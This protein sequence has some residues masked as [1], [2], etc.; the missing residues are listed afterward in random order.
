MS[1]R[2][3]RRFAYPA[4]FTVLI[5]A[6]C[7]TQRAPDQSI[8]GRGASIGPNFSVLEHH[9]GPSRAGVYA[10]PSF[11]RSAAAGI[12]LDFTTPV[13]GVTNAQPLFW[14]GQETEPDLVLMVTEQNQVLAIDASTGGVFWRRPLD[15]PVPQRVI[16]DAL[17]DQCGNIDPIGITGTPVIDPATRRIYFDL[18]TLD[19]VR[20]VKHLVYALSLDDGSTVPGWPVDVASSVPGFRDI[21][22]AQRGALT[23]LHGRLY[24]PYGGHAGDC[25]DYRGWV[26]GI[27]TLDPT[28]VGSWGTGV[29]GAGIWAPS[30]IASDG[31]SLFVGTGNSLEY[32]PP[33]DWLGSEAIIRLGDGPTFSG[34]PTDYFA[35]P[36]WPKLDASD[37]DLGASGVV[38]FDLP[39]ATPTQ[40][41]AALGK[42]TK[43]YLA[44]RAN[45]GGI[46]GAVLAQAVVTN[47]KVTAPSAYTTPLGTYLAFGGYSDGSNCS[48]YENLVA[49]QVN[50]TPLTV[51]TAWCAVVPGNGSVMVTTSDGT[52]ESVVWLV[53][54]KYD[55]RLFG[56]NADNGVFIAVTDDMGFVTH[57][58]APMAAK[59]RIYVPAV[60]RLYAFT[61]N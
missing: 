32:P 2:G 59:G 54:A 11:T 5:L 13:E 16:M 49:I 19:D 41:V 17:G 37:L 35:P 6:A 50:P 21:V 8:K 26:V 31:T 39:Q 14:D 60:D 33:P 38:L 30:G 58:L 18:L 53:G 10:H 48:P 36:D 55:N 23:L 7:G 20:L 46:G 15:P 61:V 22:H 24:I 47:I 3:S 29:I 42:D 28:S 9:N 4:F 57:F 52:S 44:D 56:F 45:L 1:V 51:S 40:L 12:R 34:L 43:L 27:S 25:A